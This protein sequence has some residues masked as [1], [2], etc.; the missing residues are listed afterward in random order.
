MIDENIPSG[1]AIAAGTYHMIVVRAG[2]G[3][4]WV[5][6]GAEGY[7]DPLEGR[8][9]PLWPQSRRSLFAG[10]TPYASLGIGIVLRKRRRGEGTERKGVEGAGKGFSEQYEYCNS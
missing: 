3:L 10:P 5:V 8:W 2:L 6:H 4:H 9:Q 7:M 1:G